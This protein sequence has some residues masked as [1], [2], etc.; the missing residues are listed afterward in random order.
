[1]PPITGM[2]FYRLQLPHELQPQNA[3][4]RLFVERAERIPPVLCMYA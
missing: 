2:R 3:W 4:P 1:M